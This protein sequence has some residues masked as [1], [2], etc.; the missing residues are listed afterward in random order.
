MA[1][2]CHVSVWSSTSR[3]RSFLRG[4]VCAFDW[5]KR[6]FAVNGAIR[7]PD[8]DAKCSR[9]SWC[10]LEL[11]VIVTRP[12]SRLS[13]LHRHDENPISRVGKQ[14][15]KIGVLQESPPQFSRQCA[16]IPTTT[17]T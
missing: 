15:G 14:L 5:G 3:T 17:R 7:D 11:L 4:S 1:N 9:L 16:A 2:T 6:A 12:A 13:I 10:Q 8:G